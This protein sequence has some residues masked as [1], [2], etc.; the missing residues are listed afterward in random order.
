MNQALE[1]G[2]WYR[3]VLP[4]EREFLAEYREEQTEGGTL[5]W[6]YFTDG[7]RKKVTEIE[8]YLTKIEATDPPDPDTR[9]N[10]TDFFI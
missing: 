8:P 5:R 4:M 6:F 10:V 2:Q 9:L 7:S 3:L 1:Q